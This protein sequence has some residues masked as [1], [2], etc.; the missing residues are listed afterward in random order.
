MC[1]IFLY[2]IYK[3]I[4]IYIIIIIIIIIIIHIHVFRPSQD[5]PVWL[6]L[7]SREQLMSVVIII[8][9]FTIIGE[10]T[11]VRSVKVLPLSIKSINPIQKYSHINHMFV[12]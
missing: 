8:I 9:F 1:N 11:L 7:T 6:E 10:K 5:S 12:L 3:N 4:Y 2:F